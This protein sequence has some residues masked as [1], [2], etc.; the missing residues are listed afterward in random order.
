MDRENARPRPLLVLAISGAIGFALGTTVFAT[1]QVAVE[2][3]QVVAGIVKYPPDN[4]FYIYHRELWTVLHQICALFL[5]AGVSEIALSRLVSGVLGMVSFQALS[6]LIYAFS[7]DLLLSVGMPFL[8]LYTRAVEHGATYPI[9]L[10]G[11]DHTYGVIGLST[12]LLVVGL[13]GSGCYRLAGFLLGFAPAVHA[14]LGA[15]LALIVAG[16]IVWDFK[17]LRPALRPAVPWF[18]AGCAVT[19]LSLGVHFAMARDVT[20]IGSD[21]A[22]QYVDAFVSGWDEHRR[23]AGL[24]TVG[25]ILNVDALLLGAAWL[26]LFR[27]DLPSRSHFILRTVIVSGLLSIPLMLLS[28]LP[29]NALPTALLTLMPN[30]L[31]NLNVLAFMPLVIGLLAT[32]RRSFWSQLAITALTVALFVNY[33]SMIWDSYPDDGTW[34]FLKLNPWHVFVVGSFALLCV[35][36]AAGLARTRPGFG[37]AGPPRAITLGLLAVTAILTFRLSPPYPFRDRTNDPFMAAVAAETHGVVAT[38]GSFHLVQLYTRRPVLLDGGALDTLPYAPDSGPAMERILRDV[39]GLNLLD[40][41]KDLERAAVISHSY[42]RPIWEHY[43]RLKWQEIGFT[44]GVT[45]VLTRA[46]WRLDLPVVAED[47]FFKLYQIPK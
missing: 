25:S 46:E 27:S 5:R 19:A 13:F 41:P 6:I 40:P 34:T 33:R 2:S 47:R 15:W 38:G 31:V 14:S 10:M 43:S 8:I 3:A 11:T 44:F 22:A 45:Q 42:N 21:V 1:W 35:A 29:P 23:A 28:W 26:L 7:S 32:Y 20:R 36:V 12:A 17:R 9:S 18:I 37:S 24:I 39:Y 30:R 16:C 4:P